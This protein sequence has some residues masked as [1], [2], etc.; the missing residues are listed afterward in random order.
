MF[1]ASLHVHSNAPNLIQHHKCCVMCSPHQSHI[2]AVKQFPHMELAHALIQCQSSCCVHQCNK[3]ILRVKFG[4]WMPIWC[5]DNLQI[6]FMHSKQIHFICSCIQI[7]FL[8]LYPS[9]PGTQLRHNTRTFKIR[10][11][12]IVYQDSK[13]PPCPLQ[14]PTPSF[15]QAVSNPNGCW[16]LR[17]AIIHE[18][19]TSIH[20][21]PTVPRSWLQCWHL[22]PSTF[23]Q[24]QHGYILLP[25]VMVSVHTVHAQ[26]SSN[27]LLA[28]K[29]PKT[30]K[31]CSPAY[32][33]ISRRLHKPYP[34]SGGTSFMLHYMCIPMPQPRP[35]P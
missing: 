7:L 14:R 22:S 18:L 10:H 19:L 11:F 26:N 16:P 27:T 23:V 33:S 25:K 12:S 4:L 2:S 3:P 8:Y 9:K 21:P 30:N 28:I 1:D 20:L 5:T 34:P 15:A 6:H 31:H 32:H 29:Y 13:D 24:C 17:I 35:T